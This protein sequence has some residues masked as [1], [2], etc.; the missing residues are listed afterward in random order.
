M[1]V[2]LEQAS[3][4]KLWT[5]TRHGNGEGSTSREATDTSTGSVYRGKEHGMLGR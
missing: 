4:A 3:K 1:R 5:P 2:K